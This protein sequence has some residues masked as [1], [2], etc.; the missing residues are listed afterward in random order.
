MLL[1]ECWFWGREDSGFG[2]SQYWLG[3]FDRR[4]LGAPH[5]DDYVEPYVH[6]NIALLASMLM[7]ADMEVL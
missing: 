5:D 6:P 3:G 4:T 1:L 2:K 7:A